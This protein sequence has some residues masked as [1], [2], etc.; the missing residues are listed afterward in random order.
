MSGEAKEPVSKKVLEEATDWLVLRDASPLSEKEQEE[1]ESW[2]AVDPEHRSAY[3][4]VAL[5]WDEFDGIGAETVHGETGALSTV[6]AF[7]TAGVAAGR[8]RT[9][10]LRRAVM[11][12]VAA[13]ILVFAIAG[14]DIRLRFQSDA[15]T[16]V[17]ETST[18]SL[19]DGSTVVLN[20]DSAIAV[21][22]DADERRI[23]LLRGE[24]QFDVVSN[25][26]RPFRVVAGDGVSTAL[27]TVFL[28]RRRGGGAQVTVLEGR[29][30]V[31]YGEGDRM[32]D[33]AVLIAKQ[34]IRYAAGK[35]LGSVAIV[36]PRVA[37]AWRRGKMIFEDRSLDEVIGEL[38]RYHVGTIRILGGA[39]GKM[40]VNGVFDTSDPIAA[41]EA[42]D[43]SLPLETT[44][45][46]DYLILLH[47]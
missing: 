29:V 23:R 45:L 5:A 28:V 13:S 19:P 35:G 18:V 32:A 1:F 9:T 2:L 3:E 36:D 46:S 42:L 21:S 38:N 25:P 27:G 39:L 40:K 17:G 47:R 8:R 44:R 24:A 26:A 22:Y 11:G 43:E 20:T 14:A 31:V 41:V 4:E 10:I 6:V 12:A 37:S 30:S 33:E 16:A 7:S 34:Q 15:M